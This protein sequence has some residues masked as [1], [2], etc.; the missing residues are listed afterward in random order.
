MKPSAGTE[1]RKEQLNN[2]VTPLLFLLSGS[3]S[4]YLL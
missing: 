4:A 3:Y 2:T 1:I